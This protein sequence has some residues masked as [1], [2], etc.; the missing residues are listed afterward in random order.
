[1]KK[2]VFNSLV[3]KLSTDYFLEKQTSGQTVTWNTDATAAMLLWPDFIA[4]SV[5]RKENFW[6]HENYFLFAVEII[7]EGELLVISREKK[8]LLKPGDAYLI[9][10]GEDSVLRSGPGG[11]C[12][13]FSIGFRGAI[14]PHLL[15]LNGLVQ[16]QLLSLPDP[17][18]VLRRLFELRN[19]LLQKD[20]ESLIHIQGLCFE[21]LSEL[22]G[23]AASGRQDREP[24]CG[25]L[26]LQEAVNLL[27]SN[28]TNPLR[29]SVLAE[30]LN[31]SSTTLN[32]LFR[33]H[34]GKSPKQYFLELKLQTAADLLASSTLTI[35]QIAGQTGFRNQLHFSKMFKHVRG[36]SPSAFR[37]SVQR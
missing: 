5:W 36:L 11:F 32:R 22:S 29:L 23:I 33:K 13:K 15:S 9:P 2:F 12:R 26:R 20:P 19:L 31:L 27:G 17:E 28:I 1:M 37:K 30:T 4:H 8:T 3:A 7:V 6:K 10:R 35:K 16:K 18:A 24:A 25:D 21:F 14:L 34:F